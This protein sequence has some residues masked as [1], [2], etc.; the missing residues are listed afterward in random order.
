MSDFGYLDS[1]RV[2]AAVAAKKLAGAGTTI[3]VALGWQTLTDGSVSLTQSFASTGG[4][5]LQTDLFG[6]VS[7]V[8]GA[9]VRVIINGGSF[10]N[11]VVS[12][13][14]A[15]L[16]IG[17]QRVN[18]RGLIEIPASADAIT[19]TVTAQGQGVGIL[20]SVT[21]GAGLFLLAEEWPQ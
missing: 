21:P 16:A 19:Y 9:S 2:P 8:V 17:T 14:P 11:E 3:G 10:S 4:T 5:W 12:Q 6:T 7:V 15:T 18:Q 13:E 20:S 1:P